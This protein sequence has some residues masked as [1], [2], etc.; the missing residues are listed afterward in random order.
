MWSGV[1]SRFLRQH[2]E[3]YRVLWNL[4]QFHRWW[5]VHCARN[6]HLCCQGPWWALTHTYTHKHTNLGSFIINWL[7]KSSKMANVKIYIQTHIHI[8]THRYVKNTIGGATQKVNSTVIWYTFSLKMPKIH[9][10]AVCIDFLSVIQICSEMQ[11]LFSK[12]FQFK[13]ISKHFQITH[14]QLQQRSIWKSHFPHAKSVFQYFLYL[15]Y[16]HT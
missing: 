15:I 13:C 6:G 8:Y 4:Q 2:V 11:I 10:S 14:D 16:I 3:R 7:A 12:T 1:A 9:A 5:K